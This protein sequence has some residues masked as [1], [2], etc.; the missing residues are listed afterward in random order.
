MSIPV[1]APGERGEEATQDVAALLGAIA[2]LPSIEPFGTD[3]PSLAG[4]PPLIGFPPPQPEPPSQLGVVRGVHDGAI[5]ALAVVKRLEDA[6]AACKAAL[7]GRLMGAVEVERVLVDLDRNQ[8]SLAQSSAVLEA[9]LVLGIP[10]RTAAALT[11]HCVEVLK[12]PVT[13]KAL[14]A[15]VLSWRHACTIAD[16]ITTVKESSGISAPE[17]AAFQTRLLV[18][19]PGAT[20]SVFASKARRARESTFPDTLTTATKE[21]FTRRKMF[22]EE[23]R[24]G[25]SWLSLHL[26]T[27]AAAGIMTHCTRTARAIKNHTNTHPTPRP[28]PGPGFGNGVGGD[29]G[30]YRTLDQLRVDVAALLLMGQELPANNYTKT[31]SNNASTSTTSTSSN[32]PDWGHRGGSAGTSGHCTS[33]SSSGGFSSGFGVRLVDPEPIWTHTDPDPKDRDATGGGAI[34]GGAIGGDVRESC[35]GREADSLHNPGNPI[36]G[37]LP[38]QE[39]P[40]AEKGAGRGLGGEGSAVDDAHPALAQDVA[41][42]TGVDAG[43]SGA[44]TGVD[45]GVD[46][47]VVGELVGDGSGFVN[48]VID[49][50]VEDQQQEYLDQLHAL[51]QGKVITD[52]PLP[53]ALILLKVPFLGLLGITDEPAELVGIGTSPV[54]EEIA[55]KLMAASHTFLRVLTDPISG[56]ALALNPDR[57]TLSNAEKAVL[58]A[59]TGGC[60]IPNCPYPVMDTEPDH[61]NAWEHGGTTAMTNLR[62]ACARHHRLKHFKDDKDRHGNYRRYQEPH[63]QNIRLR[64]WTPQPTPD[65]RIGWITPSGNYQKPQ[66]QEP[67]RTQYPTWLKKH[68]N[69][70]LNPPKENTTKHHKKRHNP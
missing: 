14:Q 23:G 64:G 12:H 45:V 3:N 8:S 5:A 11:H 19:A 17:V 48:G 49:G 27:L 2:A 66:H 10:E 41:G 54:P 52:P 18:L 15:G 65:G 57:Y 9:A 43:D 7:L 38:V 36:Q 28:N 24:D 59:L 51:A 50:I 16:E 26:P 21:A 4:L 30:E 20:A 44:D 25:M 61:L 22:C 33:E 55:R 34:G 35:L 68:I 13:F 39:R 47:L 32:V 6:T 67:Q 31:G 58:Q 69:H 60:Y 62:P 53:K 29:R 1:M 70:T 56:E 46:V 42:D 63:R 37:Y 40:A